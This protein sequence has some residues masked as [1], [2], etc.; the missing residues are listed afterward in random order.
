LHL[1]IVTRGDTAAGLGC[2]RFLGEDQTAVLT[3]PR[4]EIEYLRPLLLSIAADDA[5][6]AVVSNPA[7]GWHDLRELLERDLKAKGSILMQQV[8]TALLGLRQL[9]L[10]TP[11]W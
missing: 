11:E 6:P 4:V 9:P 2:V 3:L 10:L 5:Q 8:R 1:L 7:G